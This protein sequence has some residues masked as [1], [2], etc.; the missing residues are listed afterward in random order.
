MYGSSAVLCPRQTSVVHRQGRVRLLV[1]AIIFSAAAAG[2]VGVAVAA[3][4]AHQAGRVAVAEA[5]PLHVAGRGGGEHGG[6]DRGG[7]EAHWDLPVM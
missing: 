5:H 3:P 2:Q 7:V 4:A 1:S 6:D